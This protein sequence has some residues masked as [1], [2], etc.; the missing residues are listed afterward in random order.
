MNNDIQFNLPENVTSDAIVQ[1][2][3]A[4]RGRDVFSKESLLQCTQ[5]MIAMH[6]SS[7]VACGILER[8]NLHSMEAASPALD[9]YISLRKKYP[10]IPFYSAQTTEDVTDAALYII[11]SV[12]S[13]TQSTDRL[14]IL[15]EVCLALESKF[16]SGKKLDKTLKRIRMQTTDDILHAIDMYFV[17]RK[18]NPDEKFVN[19]R[20]Q[21]LWSDAS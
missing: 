7:E 21:Q 11:D 19:K 3:I 16:G 1:I 13:H 17:M 6:Y 14:G 5:E 20:M 2:D 10:D 9:A 12:V 8:L 18:M 4:N 15:N